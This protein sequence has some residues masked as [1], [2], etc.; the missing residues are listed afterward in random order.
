MSLEI[1]EIKEELRAL[2]DDYA[3]LGDDKK[4]SEQMLL[5]TPS[6]TYTAYMNG[7]LV[8][9]TT[10]K[11]N[12]EAEFKGHASQVKKY[13]TL[14]GQHAVKIDGDTATGISFSQIKMIREQDGKD[15]IADYSVRY[16][17]QYVRQDGKWLIKNRAGHFI[18]AEARVLNNA[19]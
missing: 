15:I 13:F 8:S 11:D 17:D 16:D 9:S 12:L 2:I 18:I 10:G 14:N 19:H 3:T 7:V 6:A 5:F 1:L 4:L